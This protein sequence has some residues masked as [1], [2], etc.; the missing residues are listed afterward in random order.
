MSD[1]DKCTICEQPL[2]KDEKGLNKK[3]LENDINRG[4]WRCLRC[5]SEFLE[6]DE[7]EL[8][9]KIEEFK[10]EGCKLFQ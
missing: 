7:E 5:M 3:I 4:I 2:T 10:T 6:C 8:R 9:D 1:S